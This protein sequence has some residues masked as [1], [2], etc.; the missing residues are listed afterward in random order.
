MTPRLLQLLLPADRGQRQLMKVWAASAVGYLLYS[1]VQALEVTFGL[2]DRR[3]S[4]ALIAA[5]ALK[6]FV[7]Y[8]LYR[9]GLN[10]RLRDPGMT[11]PQIVIGCGLSLWSYAVTGPARGA[12]LLILASTLMYG[13]FSLSS[14]QSRG[15]AVAALLGLG[16]VMTGCVLRAY[17]A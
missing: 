9:T 14:R 1:S 6:T 16:A 2:L 10:R 17:A 8:L 12:I 4:D 3:M 15:I 11:L 7:F 13:T 5:M